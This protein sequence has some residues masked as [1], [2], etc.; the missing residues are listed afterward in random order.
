MDFKKNFLLLTLVFLTN[1]KPDEKRM[2]EVDETFS[3]DSF[4]NNSSLKGEKLDLGLVLSPVKLFFRDSLLFISSVGTDLNV[5]VFNSHDNYTKI[6]GIIPSGVGP[7]EMT[8]VI[9]IQFMNDSV[10]WAHDIQTFQLKN[11]TLHVGLDSIYAEHNELIALDAGSVLPLMLN[12]ERLISTTR[13]INPFNRF[14]EFDVID[15]TKKGVGKYPGFSRDIPYTVAAEVY[16]AF[17]KIH[18]NHEKFVLAYEHTDLIEF[19]NSDVKLLKRFQGP[20]IFQP[21][22]ELNERNGHFA[23]RRVYEKTKW[24]YIAVDANEDEIFLL[25]ANGDTRKKG[26]GEEGIH[27]NHIVTIDW[28]GNPLNYYELDHGVTTITVDFNKRI[29]YGLDRMES[30]VYAFEY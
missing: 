18:P 25:Y 12:N 30:E 20:H 4:R 11:Y 8:S 22:F 3:I 6:G 5:S 21:E 14:Y 7:N 23:M 29:I 17:S 24:A 13:E 15:K 16:N 1:C 19:Y 9:K 27:H 26:E 10:F 28:E 2:N